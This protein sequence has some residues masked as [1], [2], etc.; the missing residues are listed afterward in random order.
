MAYQSTVERLIEDL[1]NLDNTQGI[2]A[3]RDF[4]IKK[5][6]EMENDYTKKIAPLLLKSDYDDKIKEL[7]YIIEFNENKNVE[8]WEK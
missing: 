4:V 3:K 6:E 2:Y 8:N 7:N 5:F 1:K